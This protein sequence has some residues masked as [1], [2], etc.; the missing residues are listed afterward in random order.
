METTRSGCVL[1]GKTSR[2]SRTLLYFRDQQMM[3]VVEGRQ[4]NCWICKQVGHLAK[5]YPQKA[6]DTEQPRP[7][8]PLSPSIPPTLLTP[9]TPPMRPQKEKPVTSGRGSLEE[10]GKKEEERPKAPAP[11]E[12]TPPFKPQSAPPPSPVTQRTSSA[13]TP[14]NFISSNT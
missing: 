10:E 1:I 9:P 11:K 13:E 14:F 12:S 4:P 8:T 3:V 6:T 2:P 5:V 7:P